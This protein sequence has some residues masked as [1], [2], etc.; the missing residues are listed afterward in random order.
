MNHP[1]QVSVVLANWNGSRFLDA[2]IA[3]VVRQSFTDWEFIIVDTG[4]DDGSREIIGQWA[5]KEQRIKP[6]LL[7]QRLICPAALNLGL[8]EATG[9]FIARIES[10]DLWFP[11]R[12]LKQVGFLGQAENEGVGVC[13]SDAVL[14]DD[15]GG[16]IGIKRFPRG[17]KDCL[18]A[19]WFRNPFCHSSVLMRRG[20]FSGVGGYDEAF[21]LVEDLDLWLRAGRKWGLRNLPEP[22]VCY[23]VWDGSLT[24]KRLWQLALRSY[25]ARARAAH[26]A[27]CERP[28]FA[29]VYSLAA[30][31]VAWLPPRFVRAA[32]EFGVRRFG[33]RP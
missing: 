5:K 11:D 2:A 22:L 13:G 26:E 28:W 21:Y 18:R 33:T 17:E 16:Q 3:S 24:T 30:L 4:S 32:F 25:K 9:E 31:S 1:P 23:R 8:T 29:G 27:G 10:D 12:L 6:M 14:I 7:P 19:L 15:A 20:I